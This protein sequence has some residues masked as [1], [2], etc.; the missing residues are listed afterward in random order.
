MHFVSDHPC[1]LRAQAEHI[2]ERVFGI[3]VLLLGRGLIGI[4]EL[5]VARAHEG[6]RED[7]E[8]RPTQIAE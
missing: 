1:L 8:N 6:S 5:V 2:V 4:A 7:H 3:P